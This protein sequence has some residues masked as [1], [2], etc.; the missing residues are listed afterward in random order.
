MG[1]RIAIE[2]SGKRTFMEMAGQ[3]GKLKSASDVFFF[4]VTDLGVSEKKLSSIDIYVFFSPQHK[5]PEFKTLISW[6]SIQ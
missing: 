5:N 2:L 4:S 1:K 6:E 3:E